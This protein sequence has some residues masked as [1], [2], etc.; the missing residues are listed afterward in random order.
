MEN[1][2]TSE[3]AAVAE[4][5]KTT[6]VPHPVTITDPM[7]IAPDIAAFAMPNGSGG[8]TLSLP[9]DTQLGDFRDRPKLRSGV[10]QLKDIDSFVD[11]VN[12]F[13]DE[14]SAIFVNNHPQNPSIT[15]VLNYHPAGE[16]SS[17]KPRF[18]DH[19]SK[20]NFPMSTDWE[21]WTEASGN[22]MEMTEFA[23]FLEDR[24]TDVIAVPDFLKESFNGDLTGPDQD[25]A[26]MLALLGGSVCSPEKLMSLSRDLQI[27]EESRVIQKRDLSSGQG[28][29]AFQTEHTDEEGVKISIPS[30]FLIAIPVFE[31][32]T[33]YRITVRLRYRIAG[34]KVKWTMILHRPELSFEAAVE[35]AAD[36]VKARCELP[37]M[38]G[39]PE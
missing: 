21:I 2:N 12:R 27:N 13:K 3:A 4:I 34:G 15:G 36:E 7:G 38:F 1:P 22:E 31:R 32:G 39:S 24:A 5:V 18:G 6:L 35:G 33:R 30:M 14:G 10:A 25:L 28:H 20:Y 37:L 11:H 17:V 9:S 23:E 8:L 16:T 29:I 26:N 19:Q